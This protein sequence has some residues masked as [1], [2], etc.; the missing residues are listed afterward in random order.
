MKRALHKPI[1]EFPKRLVLKLKISYLF[2]KKYLKSLHKI[3]IEI[4]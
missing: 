3:N 1:P 2:K 4:L